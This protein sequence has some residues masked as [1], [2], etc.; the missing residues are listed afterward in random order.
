VT[1][2]SRQPTLSP[3]LGISDRAAAVPEAMR[4]ELLQ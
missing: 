2:S 1:I 4:Q 3:K